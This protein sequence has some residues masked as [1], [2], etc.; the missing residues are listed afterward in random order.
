MNKY[1]LNT[2]KY[3]NADDTIQV[4]QNRISGHQ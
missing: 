1:K 2:N 3:N 4:R